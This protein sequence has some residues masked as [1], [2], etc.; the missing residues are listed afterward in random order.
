MNS[1]QI[2]A[3]F[4]A[5]INKIVG[6]TPTAR[7]ELHNVLAECVKY[8]LCYDKKQNR[9]CTGYGWDEVFVDWLNAAGYITTPYREFTNLPPDIQD[10]ILFKSEGAKVYFQ[11]FTE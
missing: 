6:I 9:I 11:I 4:T 10:Y 8:E 7:A 1:L 2:A 5:K 3:K